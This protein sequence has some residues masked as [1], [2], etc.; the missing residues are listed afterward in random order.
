MK[1]AKKI[2]ISD[3]TLRDGMHS[4][5]HQYTIEQVTA[6]AKALDEAKVDSIEISHGDGLAGSSFNY[7]FGLQTDFEWIEAVAQAV[8]HAK[9]ATLL[10]PGIGTVHD[11]EESYRAGARVVRIATHCTEADISKQH[12]EHARKLGMDTVGF[13]MMAHMIPAAEL[14]RQAK[15]MESYGATCVYVT[16]SGGALLMHEVAEKTKF[17]RDA[18]KPETEV[19]IHCHHNLSLLWPTPSSRSRT[20]RTGWML[21]SPAW[22]PVPAIRRW[23]CSLRC[24]IVWAGSMAAICKS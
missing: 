16:D 10:I 7:G 19:G 24:S 8:K 5:R 15:L 20:A 1:P 21:R 22:A 14:A 18:L 11:L 2:Y 4:R 6:I 12:I 23:K 9:V 13:L 3:V 17:M